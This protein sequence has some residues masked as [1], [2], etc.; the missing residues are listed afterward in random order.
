MTITNTNTA[1][2]PVIAVAYPKLNSSSFESS[3]IAITLDYSDSF[4]TQ[5]SHCRLWFENLKVAMF[6]AALILV[7]RTLHRRLREW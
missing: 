7:D 5:Y 2:N 3:F 6:Q 1:T 4:N